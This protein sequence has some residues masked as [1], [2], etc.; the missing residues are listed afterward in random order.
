MYG[1]GAP[2]VIGPMNG[3]MNYPPGFSKSE[4]L[5]E[6]WFTRAGRTASQMVNFVVPGKREA[7]ILLVANERHAGHCP[8]AS[9]GRSS[10]WL[11]TALI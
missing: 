10:S 1:I 5:L 9:L 7:A 6:R 3:G 11:K 8:M 2:M 4:G